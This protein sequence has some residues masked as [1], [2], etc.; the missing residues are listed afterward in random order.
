AISARLLIALE[1]QVS[2]ALGFF[3]HSVERAEAIVRLIE[4]GLAAF[5]RLLDHRAPDFLLVATLPGERL[6]GLDDQVERLLPAF[7]IAS[8][9]RGG[10][11]AID[12]RLRRGLRQRRGCARC[13]LSRGPPA[14]FADEIVVIDE[15]VAVGDQQI[16]RRVL[17]AD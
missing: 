17:D 8:S 13:S 5:E 6:D 16:G 3:E 10:R 7:L 4:A 1:L 9:R 12:R 14:L 2:A 11:R 15:L